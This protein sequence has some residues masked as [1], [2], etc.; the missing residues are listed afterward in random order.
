MHCSQR[1]FIACAPFVCSALVLHFL[2]VL[3]FPPSDTLVLHFPVLQIPPNDFWPCIFRSCIF[4]LVTLGPPFSVLHFPAFDIFLVLHFLV[5]HFQC[6][7]P[8]MRSADSGKLHVPRT[9]TSFGDRSFAV[10]GPRTWK[11]LPDAIRDSSL[12][13]LTVKKTL[14]IIFICL[15][16]AVRVIFDWRLTNVL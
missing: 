2:Q 8:G 14:K 1:R 5:L 3:H 10:V 6:H 13:F 11:N 7:R 16:A 9:Q 4:H 15:T 12:S